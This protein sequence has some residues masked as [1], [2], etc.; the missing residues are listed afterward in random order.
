MEKAAGRIASLGCEM[1][2]ECT[3]CRCVKKAVTDDAG[4]AA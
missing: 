2:G 3:K 4:L 1:I